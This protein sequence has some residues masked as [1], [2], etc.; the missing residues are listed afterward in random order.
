MRT[1]ILLARLSID[2]G[3]CAFHSARIR[4]SVKMNDEFKE[5]RQLPASLL[6][7][8]GPVGPARP[9]ENRKMITAGRKW[10]QNIASPL[11]VLMAARSQ[12]RH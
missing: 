6:A 3:V 8:Q 5:V 9:K 2:V 1:S 4:L 10:G 7:Q 12:L 11:S